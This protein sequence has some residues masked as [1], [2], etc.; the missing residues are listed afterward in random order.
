MTVRLEGS[1]LKDRTHV[2]GILNV[3]PDSFSDGGKFFD[4]ETAVRAGLSM[5]EDGADILDIGGESSRPGAQ[6][7]PADEEIK[8]IAPVI[9]GIRRESGVIISVDTYKPEV[10]EAAFG[11]GADI[12]N[13][14]TGLGNER[15]AETVSRNG[16]G[17]IIMHMKGTPADMQISPSYDDV[18]EEVKAFLRLRVERA[19]SFGIDSDGIIIDPGICF[20]KT[21]DHN[22][23]LL[24]RLKEFLSLNRPVLVGT[25]RKSF[26]GKLIGRDSESGRLFGTLGSV[27]AA[28]CNGASIVR[29]H[30]VRPCVETVRVTDRIIR[31]IR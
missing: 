2:M 10:A 7:V 13:D 12:V 19:L 24:G 3:T 22:L 20:G 31:R 30:D 17:V 15:M 28:V 11:C 27:A 18:V 8:R 23:E 26:I 1:A 25:S 16:G 21:L 6:P 9:E 14:I 4:C 29:V 5:V